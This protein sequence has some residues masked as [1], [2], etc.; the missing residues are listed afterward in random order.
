MSVPSHGNT[1]S[2]HASH[3][4]CHQVRAIWTNV[5]R[6]VSFRDKFKQVQ[7]NFSEKDCLVIK[8]NFQVASDS[9]KD[10]TIVINH[11]HNDIL[12]SAGWLNDSISDRELN[13]ANG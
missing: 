1:A 13:H 5:L 11:K 8:L 12:A 10:T 4:F 6:F 7:E 9:I 3:T 2:T